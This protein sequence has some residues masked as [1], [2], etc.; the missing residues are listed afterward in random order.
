MAIIKPITPQ[1]V[2]PLK[3]EITPDFIIDAFNKLIAREFNGS[4]SRIRQDD[5]I[6]AILANTADDETITREVIFKNK[7]LDVEDIYRQH[8]W[9]VNYDSPAYNE[10]Y[11][12]SYLF[13]KKK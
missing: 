10:S 4:H 11:E 9:D 5:I 2:V 13:T 6:E 8:G 3:L 12:P 1:E 7:W